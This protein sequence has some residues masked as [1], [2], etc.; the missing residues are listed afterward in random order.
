MAN[1]SGLGSFAEGLAG[2]INRGMENYAGLITQGRQQAIEQER[3]GMEK[4][5]FG[6][7]K[8][9]FAWE[10]QSRE[11]TADLNTFTKDQTFVKALT[12]DQQTNYWTKR[13]QALQGKKPEL[14]SLYGLVAQSGE[15]QKKQLIEITKNIETSIKN[16]D[17]EGNQIALD[18][19]GALV[20]YDS[21][22]YLRYK[23]GYAGKIYSDLSRIK[24]LKNGLKSWD[25]D[26][27]SAGAIDP[28]SVTEEQKNLLMSE[29]TLEERF[30]SNAPKDLLDIYMKQLETGKQKWEEWGYGQKALVG[31]RG[32]ILRKEKVPIKPEKAGSDLER[33]NKELT[34]KGKAANLAGKKMAMKYGK[35]A[36]FVNTL[37]GDTFMN[38]N[39]GTPDQRQ[40][41]M[42]EWEQ[43]TEK[44]LPKSMRSELI[45]QKKQTKMGDLWQ[46]VSKQGSSSKGKAYLMKTYRYSDAQA[47]DIIKQGIAAGNIK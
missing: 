13:A 4:Q 18:Q 32:D 12:P 19:L 37:T 14:A 10:K 21:P 46:E 16:K 26:P 23:H 25:I 30:V 27:K 34:M 35:D 36:F 39:Y 33:E 17:T 15:E 5:K 24:E 31:E 22:A 28:K 45:G 44:L 6:F 11:D 38:P 40:K 47:E 1:L 41:I 20:G 9:K 3:F 43:T 8:D 2:G 7:E 29:P 42:E